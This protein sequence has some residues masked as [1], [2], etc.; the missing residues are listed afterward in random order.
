MTIDMQSLRLSVVGDLAPS[1]EESP[2]RGG[3]SWR[4]FGRATQISLEVE[5]LRGP[6]LLITLANSLVVETG[7]GF[8]GL[9]DLFRQFDRDE[10]FVVLSSTTGGHVYW[11][12]EIGDQRVV[13]RQYVNC[14]WRSRGAQTQERTLLREDGVYF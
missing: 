6:H 1:V 10:A 4:L 5:S 7:A 14:S 13:P 11:W 8:D 12:L 9:Y 3:R 2:Q